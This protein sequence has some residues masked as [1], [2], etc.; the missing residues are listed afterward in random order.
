MSSS[1]YSLGFTTGAALIRET[2]LVAKLYA[3]HSEWNKV[4]AIVLAHNSFQARAQSSLKKLYAEVAKR[5]K[6]L[7]DDQLNMFVCASERQVKALIWLAI[8][9]QYNLVRDFTSEAIIPQYET[10]R[11]Q[12]THNDYNSF[13]NNK[14]EWHEN[15]DRSSRQTKAK[16]RQIVF[17][18]MIECGLLNEAHE[19]QPFILDEKLTQIIVANRPDDVRLF[20]GMG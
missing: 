19:I 14:A 6:R 18:M 5:L 15:L 9:R 10:A 11:L 7:S 16:A 17:R 2:V 3:E 20:P 8:C 12:L 1:E 4:R 13:F